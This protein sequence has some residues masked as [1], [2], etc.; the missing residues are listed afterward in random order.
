M[1]IPR[2]S[3]L[4][5]LAA[6]SAWP[7]MLRA[8]ACAHVAI[9]GGGFG[10]ASV[11]RYLR[12]QSPHT[13]VTLIAPSPTFA[14]CPFSNHFLAGL[15]SWDSICQRYEGLRHAGV[16]VVH[17][18]AQDV[19]TVKRT[20]RL[21]QGSV[22]HWDQLVLAPGIDIRWDALPGYDQTAAQLAPHAWQA[23]AQTQLLRQQLQA[24]RDGGTFVMV[25]PE[26]PF[27]CPPGPYERASLV[28]HY[29]Q[30]HK[31]R[32]KIL[33]LD[34]K[35]NFSK[36][37]LF[38]SAWKQCYGG[39]IEWV[40]L[41]HDG[42]VVRVDAHQREA[43]TL[44]GQIHRADVLNV[45]PPQQAG[46]IAARAG[47]VDASGW[48]PVHGNTFAATQVPGVYVLGD[49]SA[50]GPMPKSAFAANN[51]ARVVARAIAAQ[52]DD[53]APP[54]ALYANTCYSLIAPDYGVSVTGIYQASGSRLQDL[55]GT[56]GN[57]PA[58]A[59]PAFRAAEA[60]YSAAWYTNT[61]HDIW[62]R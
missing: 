24:M 36:K 53:R 10:G 3:V 7:H 62:G 39:M 23:G 45:I 26:P 27:R 59:S 12:E 61:C 9:V 34:A 14:T 41:A 28:A 17:A 33:L 15:R 5:A 1:N 16:D 11:A 38:L 20:L 22:L 54:H 48:V 30:Q 25:I 47:T 42:Q 44:F 8:R 58:R 6:S 2:R 31:P 18:T 32:S 29:F 60:R 55:P 49:A 19:D 13:R 43:E 21:D 4:Q 50:A 35:E 46:Q 57:S 37:D 51:Q 40:S 52:I 56:V